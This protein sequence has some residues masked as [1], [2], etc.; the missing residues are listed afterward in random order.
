MTG[1]LYYLMAY[2]DY[3]KKLQD[4]FDEAEFEPGSEYEIIDGRLYVSAWPN[5][6]FPSFSA[7]FR[8]SGRE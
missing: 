5:P 7:I 4:E 1:I 2:P 3:Q 6:R 8:H